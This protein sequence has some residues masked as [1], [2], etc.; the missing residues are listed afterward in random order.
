MS[1]FNKIE[2]RIDESLAGFVTPFDDGSVESAKANVMSRI[3]LVDEG[4]DQPLSAKNKSFAWLKVAAVLAIVFAAG[5]AFFLSGNVRLENSGSKQA[6]AF[7]PDGSEMVLT[8][9][10]F[11]EY[12]VYS[13]NWN[14]SLRFSGEA[15]FD[16]NSGDKFTVNTDGGD[17]EVL[18]TKFTL[19]ADSND[20]FIHCTEGSVQVSNP[21]GASILNPNEF[22]RVERGL[23]TQKASYFVSGFITPRK[24][25]TLSFESVPVGIVISELEKVF[26]IEIKNGLPSNLIYSGIL[27]ISD[28]NQCLQVFCKP[29]GAIFD[30]NADGHVSIHL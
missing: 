12:N 10:S 30:K 5:V 26:K 1:D 28:E 23:I 8:P 29:F 16:V 24:D 11:A 25:K 13:W 14:R 18:G 7:L 4:A 21:T 3:S 20:L 27:D 9:G 19:W 15:Y 2:Q 6:S 22:L 17:I